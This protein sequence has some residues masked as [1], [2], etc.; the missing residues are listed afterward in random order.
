M[1]ELVDIRKSYRI[2]PNLVPVLHGISTIIQSGELV[3]I[4]GT[5]GSGK[6]TLMNI[7]GLLDKPTSGQY[8]VDGEDMLVATADKLAELRNRKFG[9][10]FQSFNLLPRLTALE[11]VA[12]PLSY[13]NESERAARARAMEM[14]ERVGMAE[15]HHHRPNELSGGQKQRIAI[16]RA[17]V[18]R[19]SIVLGDEPTG[20]LDT[21]VGQEIMD[22]MVQLNAEEGVTVIIITHAPE[23]AKQCRRRVVMKDG[24]L[25]HDS[26]Q[27][28][29]GTEAAA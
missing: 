26:G 5:S 25:L 16:A 1:L 28:D 22:L 6:S 20:A 27:F 2:G 9:F 23:I 12:L 29:H 15:R 17:L 21:R 11:N 24:L 4:M 7:L 18:A 8:R 14:L 3:S 10:V 19:P 13:R